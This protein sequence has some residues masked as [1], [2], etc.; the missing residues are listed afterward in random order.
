L[1]HPNIETAFEFYSQSGVGFLVMELI[2]RQPSA[3][4]TQS[5]GMKASPSLPQLA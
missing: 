4:S 5:L 1:N 3:M 2:R